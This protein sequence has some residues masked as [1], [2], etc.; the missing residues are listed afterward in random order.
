[1][2]ES[3]PGK[4]PWLRFA[5][6]GILIVISILLAFGIEAWWQERGEQRE[7]REALVGLRSD[8][9]RNL[10]A[11]DSAR[12]AHTAIRASA[13]GLLSLTGPEGLGSTNPAV[14][15]SL[16]QGVLDRHRFGPY[17][18]S[19]QA[20]INSGRW[21]RV[22]SD[23]LKAELT[24]WTQVRGSLARR[25]E[26]AVEGINNRL[27][28]RI[29]ELIPMRTLDMPIEPF[30]EAVGPSRFEADYDRLLGD[31]YFEA[32]VDERWQDA[33]NSLL[34]IERL[35][36]SARRVLSLIERELAGDPV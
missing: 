17:E 13:Q 26:E 15:D 29:W 14:V 19:L 24:L 22:E 8:F 36:E 4:I 2:S 12:T 9:E 30:R 20:L 16:V 25:E 1:V 33:Y 32:A 21:D 34:V 23:G 10:A 5:A 11:L 31:M 7:V 35:E 27:L 28:V 18:S 6:E 3:R